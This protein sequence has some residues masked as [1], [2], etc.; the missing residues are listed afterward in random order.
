MFGIFE[1]V[2]R[3]VTG[4]VI[5][6]LDTPIHG[7]TTTASLRLKR[8]KK[9]GSEYVVLGLTAS[10]NYQYAAFEPHEFRQFVENARVI[11]GELDQIAE[12]RS[13]GRL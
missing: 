13:P 6:R 2:K 12:A 1:S 7:G 9:A 5:R 4:E 10:G 8:D 3:I 11:L